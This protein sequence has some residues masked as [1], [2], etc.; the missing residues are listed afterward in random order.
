[1]VEK[2]SALTFALRLKNGLV[3]QIVL[4][5]IRV[6]N[7]VKASNKIRK[8]WLKYKKVLVLHPQSNGRRKKAEKFFESLEITVRKLN[9]YGKV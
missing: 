7:E 8:I 3:L 9:I 1:M 5:I 4:Q 6:E 2:K